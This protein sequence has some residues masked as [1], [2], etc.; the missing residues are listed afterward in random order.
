MQIQVI[1][2]C[3]A[4]PVSAQIGRVA[5]D[6]RILEP[7]ILHLAKAEQKADDESCLH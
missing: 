2:N 5:P 3:Q 6:I 4:R 1:A 7:I